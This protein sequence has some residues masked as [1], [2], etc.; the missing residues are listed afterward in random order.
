MRA[1]WTVV[2]LLAALLLQSGIGIVAPGH[3]QALDPFLLV[4]VY[5]GLT[6]GEAH[7]MLAGVGAGWVQ[8]IHFG[9]SVAGLSA[10]TKLIVGYGVGLAG[11]RFLIVGT[12][13]RL[14]AVFAAT[15]AD[16]VLFDRLALVFEVPTSPLSV[17]S[18][19][20]RAAVNAFV[21]AAVFEA[22]DF[23]LRRRE[24]RP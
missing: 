17:V 1:L 6:G 3:G 24:A 9:G 19:L 11:S 23:R 14:V 21:G 10:L 20:S 12:A 22:V 8:D 15:V 18:L 4:V 5:C 7:G 16:A 13:A 2:A